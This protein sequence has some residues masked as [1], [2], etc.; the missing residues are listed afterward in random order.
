MSHATA[1]RDGIKDPEV[2]QLRVDLAAALR[3]AVRMDWH[4]SVGNHFSA[5][6]SADGTKFLLNPRWRH[7]SLIC[8]SDLLLLDSLDEA[9]MQGSEG[10]D[11]S[12]WCIHGR[13]HARKREARCVLHVHPPYATA[14]AALA[15]PSLKSVDQCTA[16]F[17]KRIAIDRAF[18]GIADQ[19][20][21]GDRL[22]AVLGNFRRLLMGNHGVLVTGDTVAEAFEDLYMLERA[23]RT[24]V[25]AYSTGQPLNVMPDALAELTARG[26]EDYRGMAAAHFSDLKRLLDRDDPSYAT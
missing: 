15:D 14:L 21:E 12:A 1:L 6:V 7:F 16:R 18:S 11:P 9:T 3:L 4:E 26:W 13:I 5:A 25:V 24:L 17:H 19:Q 20:A 23:S 2:W 10:P 22:V 8:A